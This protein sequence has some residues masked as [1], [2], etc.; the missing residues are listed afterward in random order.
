MA[1][2]QRSF[3]LDNIPSGK[4]LLA[5]L[6][7]A[8][9]LTPVQA[10]QLKATTIELAHPAN[11]SV[12]RLP[13]QAVL[14]VSGHNHE[15]RWLSLVTMPTTALNKLLCRCRYSFFNRRL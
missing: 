2:A 1:P 9:L 3:S 7:G 10:L 12:L 6:T 8:L 13:G 5:L 4:L 11:G 15:F 14:L